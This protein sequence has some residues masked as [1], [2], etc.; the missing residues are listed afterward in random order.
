MTATDVSRLDLGDS[1]RRWV[2]TADP[3]AE[4][5]NHEVRVDLDWW[6]ISLSDRGLPGGPLTGLDDAGD[7]VVEGRC[8]ITRG[9]VFGQAAA[10]ADDSDAAL[11][12]LWHALAWGSGV[13]NRN[14]LK[15]LDSIAADLPDSGAALVA[16]AR[17]SRDLP[18]EAYRRLYP[19]DH[20]LI[21]SLGPAFF[22]KYL[23]FAGEGAP[24]HP[25]LILDSRVAASLVRIGWTSLHPGGNW[26]ATTYERYI[27]L[28]SRWRD[29]LTTG[30]AADG[31]RLDLLE[32]WLFENRPADAAGDD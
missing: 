28:L 13:R 1:A 31:P 20:A 5:M 10:A 21:S 22:T 29:E 8:V 15:R 4:I 12:L 19:G 14:N 25:C 18:I 3:K 6:N 30:S 9:H 11:R 32:R 27:G 16:A 26:P 23:Y 2:S 24:T 17:L 7:V